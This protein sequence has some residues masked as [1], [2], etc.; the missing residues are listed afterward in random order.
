MT[1]EEAIELM[2]GCAEDGPMDLL[3]GARRCERL[4]EGHARRALA[5]P[6]SWD[7]YQLERAAQFFVV[8]R[9]LRDLAAQSL[10]S[11]PKRSSASASL[12]A[13]ASLK[14]GMKP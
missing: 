13:L 8:A 11:T 9:G 10:P 5:H 7:D 12:R 2:A 6:I 3:A 1:R 14:E 4:A